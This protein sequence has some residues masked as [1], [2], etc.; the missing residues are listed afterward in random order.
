MCTLLENV[1]LSINRLEGTIPTEMGK[2]SSLR[3]LQL[4]LNL[5]LSGSVPTG[6]AE[7]E[8]LLILDVRSTLVTGSIPSEICERGGNVRI[9]GSNAQICP[10]CY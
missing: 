9:D 4:S 5:G 6:F 1:R 2:L 7:L 10:C 3:S 8:K